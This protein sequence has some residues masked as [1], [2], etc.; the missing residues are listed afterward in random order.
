MDTVFIFVDWLCPCSQSV[1]VCEQT[2]DG[3]DKHLDTIGTLLHQAQKL[4]LGTVLCSSFLVF[5][6]TNPPTEALCLQRGLSPSLP[7]NHTLA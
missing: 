1:T 5:Y 2:G 4:G 6:K 3:I 7:R